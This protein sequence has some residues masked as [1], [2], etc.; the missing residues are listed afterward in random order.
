MQE[1]LEVVLVEEEVDALVP[2][3]SAPARRQPEAGWVELTVGLLFR[4]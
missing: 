2:K 1:H 3:A 4:V